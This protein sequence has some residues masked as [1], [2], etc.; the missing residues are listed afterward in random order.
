MG[1]LKTNFFCFLEFEC[2]K[3]SKDTVFHHR[4]TMA[5]SFTEIFLMEY[6]EDTETGLLV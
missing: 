1:L 2:T 4:G 3:G 6:T 5:R